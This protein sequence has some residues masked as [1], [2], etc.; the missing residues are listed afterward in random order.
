MSGTPSCTIVKN[1]PF[2]VIVP[3][4]SWCGVRDCE[5]RGSKFGFERARTTFFA[6][7]DGDW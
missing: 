5:V 3:S 7:F 1:T 6:Y 2:G 4:S